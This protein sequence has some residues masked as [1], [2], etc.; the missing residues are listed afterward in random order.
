MAKKA[1]DKIAKSLNEALAIARGEAKPAKLYIWSVG[2]GEAQPR[3]RPM[4]G[5]KKGSG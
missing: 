1:F 3:A 2:R 5:R 4:K